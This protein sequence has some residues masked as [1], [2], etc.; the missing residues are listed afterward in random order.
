MSRLKILPLLCAALAAAPAPTLAQ[1]TTQA[2]SPV[3]RPTRTVRRMTAER[4]EGPVTLDGRLDE[5]AWQRATPSSDFTE[6]YP[7]QGKPSPERTEVRVLYDDAALYVGVRMFDAH[8]DSIAAQLARRDASGIY[9]DWVHV[10]I[11]SYHD[12]RTA[13]RFTVNPRGVKKDVYTSNDFNEDV[14]W[15]A[16]WD[17]G[18]AIDSAGWTAEYRIPLSQLRF[19]NAAGERVWGFQVMRDIARRQQRD[20]WSPWAQQDPGFV[21]RFGDLAGLVDVPAPSRLEVLPYVSSKVTRAPG[22]ANDPFYHATETRPSAGADLR[23]GLPKGLT[24]TATVNPDFGQVEVDPAVVNLSAYE[25]FYPEK[26]PFFLEGA[27]IF[28]FGQITGNNDFGSQTF[29]YSRRI[30]RAPQLR[31]LGNAETFVDA[32]EQATI[33]GA[34]KVTGKA[35]PWSIGFLD[36][37]TTEQRAEIAHLDER[38]TSP[39]EPLT[40]YLA[41][42]TRRDFRNGQTVLGLMG[43]S[44]LR[45]LDEP[46]LSNLLRGRSTLAGVDFEHGMRN[47]EWVLSG[48][49]A[50][51]SV[52]GSESAIANTQL[53]STHYFQRP[54]A[55]HLDYDPTRSSL[56]G[57][58]AELAI[59]RNGNVFGSLAVKEMSPGFEINDVGYVGRADYKAVSPF[60][61]Y[62]DFRQ[63]RYLRNYVLFVYSNYAW[64]FGNDNIFHGYGTGLNFTFRNLWSA[65]LRASTQLRAYDDRLTRGGPLARPP[66]SWSTSLDVGSDSRKRVI[67]SPS[68]SLS[69]DAGGAYTPATSVTFQ[70]RPSSS[71]LVTLGPS[72][73]RDHRSA[74]FIQ[75]VPDAAATATYGRRYVFGELRQTT[76]YMDTRVDW[77]FTPTLSFQMYAQPFVTAGRYRHLKE[78]AAPGSYAFREYAAADVQEHAADGYV[79]IDPDGTGGAAPFD[80]V[81]LN[82][83][84]RSLVGNAVL[85]WE[86]RP[87]SALFVIWQQ[88]REG[89]DPSGTFDTSHDV[90]EIFR[91]PM[92]NVF[93]VKATY[94]LGR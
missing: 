36:A 25:T 45:R 52:G 47:R 33:A 4:R 77:T 57:H 73:S 55:D 28:E 35:G 15:D 9:S 93:L 81:D 84:S 87:G 61:G 68:V 86:Y 31:V 63:R 26:R 69:R 5:P 44:T 12:R 40:N 94:W 58:E 92:R 66:Q 39:V 42:R 20:S 53:T 90:H 32:P 85:R 10:I 24:L 30:G 38:R 65:N 8:P 48:F 3:V 27:D 88:Q 75:S 43:T 50:G 14:N 72:L 41:V 21:S 67:V 62:Q 59:A 91:S 56:Q 2:A 23:Y 6:S 89:F 82:G 17:V 78:L 19:G 1:D 80:I 29:F 37:V 11:D 34:A 7:D 54:D 13:F 18:T 49:A 51:T 79:S 74:Q 60:L 22:D 76:L 71:I 46:V 16:V 83:T 64:N 70:I